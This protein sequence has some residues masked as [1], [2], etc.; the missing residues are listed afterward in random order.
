MKKYI[1]TAIMCT[2]LFIGINE[3][4]AHSGGKDELGGHFRRADCTSHFHGATNLTKNK[5]KA[6]II[7]L[8][9]KHNSNNKCTRGLTEKKVNW[10]SLGL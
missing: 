8:I 4:F 7:A 6:Q 5:S 3:A 2:T 10:S 1:V 9:K